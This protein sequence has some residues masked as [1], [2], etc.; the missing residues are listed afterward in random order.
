[1]KFCTAC[2]I[3]GH[4]K[5]IQKLEWVGCIFCIPVS[6]LCK[7]EKDTKKKKKKKKKR[8]ESVPAYLQSYRP[9]NGKLQFMKTDHGSSAERIY[10]RSSKI[11]KSVR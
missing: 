4:L 1:M 7:T 8:K 5:I 6:H 3:H 11:H 9:D 10:Y 2:E